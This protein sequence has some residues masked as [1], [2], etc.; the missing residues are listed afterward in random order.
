[1]RVA[2][3]VFV[4]ALVAA[5]S[6][7]GS[8]ASGTPAAPGSSSGGGGGGVGASSAAPAT[9]APASAEPIATQGEGGGNLT[10]LSPSGAKLRI[11]NFYRDASGKGTDLDVYGDFDATHGPKLITVPYGTVSDFF[12]PGQIDA[13]GDADWTFYPAGKTERDDQIGGQ[14][15]T[16][17]STDVITMAIGDGES[18]NKSPNGTQ[19]GRWKT[20]FETDAN[21]PLPTPPAATDAELMVD[22]IALSAM[23]GSTDTFVYTGVDGTCLPSSDGGAPEGGQPWGPESQQNYV[24]PAGSHAVSLHFAGANGAPDCKAKSPYPDTTVD[25]KAGQKAWLFYYTP[26]DKTLKSLL[27]PVQ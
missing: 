17:K 4:A 13:Q 2:A 18:T 22:G 20:F 19:L 5:C 9:A 1:M 16:L 11:A 7:S 12:D 10:S 23:P 26:D 21:N 15:E 6:G 24:Y 3:I 25:L 27:V 14:T 8:G